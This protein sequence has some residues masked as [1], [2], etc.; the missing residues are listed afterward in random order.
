MDMRLICQSIPS[1]Q[2]LEQLRFQ[3]VFSQTQL[4]HPS[5]IFLVFVTN[6]NMQGLPNKAP[7]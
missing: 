6:D 2:C 4:T 5:R 1:A 7:K 3:N